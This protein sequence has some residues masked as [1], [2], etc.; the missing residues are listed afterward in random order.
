MSLPRMATYRLQRVGGAFRGDARFEVGMG[1]T[2]SRGE[3]FPVIV[4]IG[5]AEGI[6]RDLSSI[7]VSP[8]PYTP[9]I[10]WTDDFPGNAVD[11]M[12]GGQ[13]VRFLSHSQGEGNVP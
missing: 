3:T 2:G 12:F 7:R 11:V 4:P 8:G 1:L 10:E 13:A 5:L 9:W 6:L